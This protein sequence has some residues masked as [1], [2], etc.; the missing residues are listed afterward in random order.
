MDHLKDLELNLKPDIRKVIPRGSFNLGAVIT[1]PIFIEIPLP[2][3]VPQELYI[4]IKICSPD[5]TRTLFNECKQ[6]AALARSRGKEGDN[7]FLG[8]EVDVQCTQ[9]GTFSVS[10]LLSRDKDS[11]DIVKSLHEP[12]IVVI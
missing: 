11:M 5:G 4:R 12:N 3:E 8:W 7:T 10:F 9:Y 1:Y 6:L 2:L